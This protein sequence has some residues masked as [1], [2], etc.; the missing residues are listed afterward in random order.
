MIG[1]GTNKK[2]IDIYND[3]QT[4]I[5]ILQ[6]SFQRKLVWNKEHK[7]SFIETILRGLPFPEIYT[8]VGE[9]NLKTRK[10]EVLVVDGQQRL[11]T[12]FQYITEEK[13]A[14]E[15]KKIKKF[16]DLTAEEQTNF[17]Y[18]VVVTRDLGHLP[19]EDVREIFKRINSVDYALESMEINNALYNGEYI[20][21]AKEILDKMNLYSTFKNSE[22]LRM[23]DLE[24]ILLI[25][26]TSDVGGYFTGT[27]EV[28]NYV[29]MYNDNYP[30]KLEMINDFN[31]LVD[32]LN[33]L[34]FEED[35][36]WINSRACYFT[37]LVEL[38]MIIKANVI[39]QNKEKDISQVLQYFNEYVQ[40]N[41][42]LSMFSD[43]IYSKFYKAMYQGTSSKKNRILRGEILRK[44]LKSI[45]N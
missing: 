28:E 26:V 4:G 43:N 30:R 40:E 14:F 31:K 36:I 25:M 19:M 13:D 12:I 8:A 35:S 18:Y 41:K 32:I 29:A 7:E 37:L 39:L 6:P 17:F 1:I 9:L 15:Y 21:T 2:I 23:K 11:S 10:T 24:F 34:S 3:I 45:L 42:S 38:L 5:L 44:E 33:R 22:I 16:S 27:K 20:S